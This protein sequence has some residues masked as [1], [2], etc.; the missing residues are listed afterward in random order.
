MKHAKRAIIV[1]TFRLKR[2]GPRWLAK[3]QKKIRIVTKKILL[4]NY[5]EQQEFTW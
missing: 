2:E 5:K 1:L 4:G 3:Q